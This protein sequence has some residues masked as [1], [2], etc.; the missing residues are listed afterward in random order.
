[1][2][3]KTKQKRELIQQNMKAKQLKY[4]DWFYLRGELYV[5]K[6]KTPEQIIAQL[7]DPRERHTRS[8]GNE[9][10]VR[11]FTP[12]ILDKILEGK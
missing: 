8:V 3:Y 2:V 7:L 11:Y 12:R 4:G 9:I 6:M 10:E 1:M 5:A